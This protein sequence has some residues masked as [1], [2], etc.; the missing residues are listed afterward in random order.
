[1]DFDQIAGDIVVQVIEHLLILFD[2]LVDS[3]AGLEKR[4]HGQGK[5]LPGDLGHPFHFL[6]HLGHGDR[7]GAE[8]ALIEIVQPHLLIFGVLAGHQ[9]FRQADQ[10]LRKGE[11]Q[12]SSHDVKADMRKRNLQLG[13]RRQAFDQLHIRQE[14]ADGDKHQ[15]PDHIEHQ[16]DHC[17]AF[18]RTV[19][20]DRREHGGDT[21]AD[22]LA[23]QDINHP[24]QADSAA[25]GQR[26]QNADRRGGGLNDGRENR[27]GE[28]SQ[29]RIGEGPHQLDE[30]RL[31]LEGAHGPR[32]HIHAGKEDAESH[33]YHAD[34]LR[35]FFTKKHHQDHADE[36]GDQ[37]EVVDLQADQ[38]A[39]DGGADIGAHDDI[40][41][42]AQLEKT[43]VEKPH[44]HDGRGGGGLNGARH[45]QADQHAEQWV[46]GDPLEQGFEA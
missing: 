41:G 43:C 35:E 44:H 23:E 36:Q 28:D 8:D 38:E 2:L 9:L 10:Q 18:A 26:L 22:V 45:H 24:A 29:H 14:K 25:A 32:H 6:E 46:G 27:P 7:R 39:G 12:Q 21:G 31:I 13:I 34:M 1:M 16:M 4:L 40:D 15:C 11:K 19:G 5:I 30:H 3:G 20:A 17:R 42:L 33:D 37:R